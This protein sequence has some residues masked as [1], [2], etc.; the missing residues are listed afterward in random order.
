M[1]YTESLTDILMK[2]KAE[3]WGAMPARTIYTSVSETPLKTIITYLQDNGVLVSEHSSKKSIT[4]DQGITKGNI[5]LV[6]NGAVNTLE[7]ELNDQVHSQ[8][9]SEGYIERKDEILATIKYSG[10]ESNRKVIDHVN[11]LLH[12]FYK[13]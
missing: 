13:K 1:T 5:T 12:E 2:G 4:N 9:I 7:I 10:E 6:K 3:K 8:K 11:Q